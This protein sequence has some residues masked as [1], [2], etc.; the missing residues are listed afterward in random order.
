MDFSHELY[1]VGYYFHP[2]FSDE[3]TEA[4]GLGN[5]LKITQLWWQKKMGTHG[6]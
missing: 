6:V 3:E 4:L 2:F 5:L 1:A